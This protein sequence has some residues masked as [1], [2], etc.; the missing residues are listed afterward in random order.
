MG[1]P[2]AP[3][4]ASGDHTLPHLW[5]DASSQQGVN[6]ADVVAEARFIDEPGGSVGEDPGP[7]DGEAVVG[8]AQA[9]EGHHVLSDLVVTVTGHI[10]IVVVRHPQGRVG[11]RVPNAESFAVCPPRAFNLETRGGSLS[12]VTR[13]RS[14]SA[15]HPAAAGY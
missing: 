4:T 8:H 13:R 2:R 12:R 14:S 9:L 1:P 10:S 6:E 5:S 11:K 15:P 3:L 7:G